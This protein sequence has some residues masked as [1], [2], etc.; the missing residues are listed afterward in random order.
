MQQTTT[1][2][3]SGARFRYVL[4]ILISGILLAAITGVM[5]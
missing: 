1:P 5:V 4:A 2:T 3:P